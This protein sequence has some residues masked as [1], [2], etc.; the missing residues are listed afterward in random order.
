D[1]FCRLYGRYEPFDDA[2][3]ASLYPTHRAYTDA[4]KKRIAD[5]LASGYI[6]KTDAKESRRRADQSIAGRGLA[7][8]AGCH[9]AQDLLDSAYFYLGASSQLKTLTGRLSGVIRTIAE[10]K[11]DKARK[12]LN[13]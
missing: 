8:D 7:C 3:I 4:A 13:A 5:N 10:G 6:V 1:G 11:N 2:T 9:A 12:D